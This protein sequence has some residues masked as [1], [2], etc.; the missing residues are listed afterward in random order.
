MARYVRLGLVSAPFCILVLVLFGPGLLIAAAAPN[1]PVVHPQI[2]Q[3]TLPLGEYRPGS[4]V[5][6][7]GGSAWFAIDN[8]AEIAAEEAGYVKQIEESG[9]LVSF[10]V[11]RDVSEVARGP[12]GIWFSR[13]GHVGRI[14]PGGQVEQFPVAT[15]QAYV[16]GIASGAGGYMWL[17]KSGAGSLDAIQRISSNGGVRSFRL[18]H[19]ESGPSQIT[20]GADG[21]M[22]FTEDSGERIGRITSTGKITEFPLGVQ[23]FGGIAVGP[24]GDIWF[25]TFGAIGRLVPSSGKVTLFSRREA[26][27]GPVIAGPDGRIWFSESFG[28]IGRITPSGGF[29]QIK[30]PG[31]RNG[32][33]NG[34]TV[35][36]DG[37]VWYT[38]QASAHPGVVG[39]ITLGR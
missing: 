29:S 38:A 20:R 8:Y 11:G 18:P 21:A 25:G 24:E 36:P 1:D 10:P 35:A 2:T 3:W 23:P 6:G 34:L 12:G 7:G 31:H 39:K 16:L 9:N 28:K 4:I 32:R 14:G 26:G 30:L 27:E 5:A 17:T 19:P 33:V 37:S 22:W 13:E 15:S